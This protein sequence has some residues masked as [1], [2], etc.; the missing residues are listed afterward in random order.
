MKYALIVLLYCF[1]VQA[2]TLEGLTKRESALLDTI[3]WAEGTNDRYDFTFG[4]KVFTDYTNH[5]K[6]VICRRKLC[7]S[8]AG[9]YQILTRTWKWVK[10]Q[11]GLEDFSPENQ[12][13]AALFLVTYRGVNAGDITDKESFRI[14][15]NRLSREW[16]SLPNNPYG[17]PSRNM[18]DL[19]VKY[20]SFM[21]EE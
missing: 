10:N 20:K 13:L 19:W 11:L 21:E 18:D 15:M 3:A 5:P 17:Q 12:D 8:A 7:S 14:A 4:Y 9:R 6:R 2:T 16:A 1:V